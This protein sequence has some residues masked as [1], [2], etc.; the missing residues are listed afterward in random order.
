MAPG[1]AREGSVLQE[2]EANRQEAR[3]T[4]WPVFVPTPGAVTP[5]GQGGRLAHRLENGKVLDG[6]SWGVEE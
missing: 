4:L 1:S 2:L 5:A 3:A 6:Q